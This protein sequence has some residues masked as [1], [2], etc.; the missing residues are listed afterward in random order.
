MEWAAAP[1]LAPGAAAE[2]VQ[3]RAA[4]LD[5]ELVEDTVAG[6]SVPAWVV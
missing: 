6:C 5:L 4:A 2:S 1:E 3:E